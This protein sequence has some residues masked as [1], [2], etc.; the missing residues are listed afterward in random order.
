MYKML[1][2][3]ALIVVILVCLVGLGVWSPWQQWKLNLPS[4]L[5][6]QS[7]E[8]FGSLKVKSLSGDIDVFVDGEFK[9]TA[10]ADDSDFLEIVPISP[11][12]HT[13]RMVRRDEPGFPEVIR[14]LNFEP[15]ADVVVAYE[16]GPSESFSEGHILYARKSFEN[17]G[18][19]QL[20]IF[21]TPDNTKVTLDGTYLGQ[22]PLK[23]IELD[24]NSKHKLKFEKDGY[25]PLEIDIFPDTQADRDKLKD[26]ILTLEI[27]LFERPV[28]V[29]NQ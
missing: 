8:Q 7:P 6:I 3:L 18:K 15:G 25:D 24:T 2:R 19:P 28:K 1:K 9:D 27:N 20:E 29:V 22:A 26:M 13:I 12:E 14:K 23:D 17:K 10:S 4:I 16:M 21:S 5:G 11:G